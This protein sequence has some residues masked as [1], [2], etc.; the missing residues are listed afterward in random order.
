MS[1]CLYLLC[2]LVVSVLSACMFA[3]SVCLLVAWCLG[4]PVLSLLAFLRPHMRLLF[5]VCCFL[6]CM[7]T[8]ARMCVPPL[9]EAIFILEELKLLHQLA[10]TLKGNATRAARIRHAYYAHV[11]C[12]LHACCMHMAPS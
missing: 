2:R 3:L 6:K 5:V 9:Q 4:C 1:V 12:L 10:T 11:A 8:C 7:T